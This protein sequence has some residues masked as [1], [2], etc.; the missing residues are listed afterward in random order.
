MLRNRE[1]LA[2]LTAR[3]DEVGAAQE[4]YRDRFR[5]F[6]RVLE[7]VMDRREAQ[8]P[9]PR[10]MSADEART[11][12]EGGF[13]LMDR[14][15]LSPDPA[16]SGGTFD[17]LLGLVEE[18]GRMSPEAV[19]AVRAVRGSE[20]FPDLLM[21]WFRSEEPVPAPGID[22]EDARELWG[23]LVRG[24]LKPFYERHSL[25]WSDL[26]KPGTWGEGYCP[27]CGGAPAVE[28][29]EGEEGRRV[30]LCHRCSTSWG[31][32]RVTCPFCGTR[33]HEKLRYLLIEDDPAHRVDV[34]DACKGYL[35]AA[36][37]RGLAGGVLLEAE[38]LVTPHLDVVAVRE[39]YVRK[40]PNI[41]GL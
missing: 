34:C 35:K 4:G 19:G 27:V 5:F 40:S 17:L 12:L 29:F 36:D 23:F 14:M 31:F 38:D 9:S 30:L 7:T 37:S 26:V 3:L 10:A 41:L 25:A 24:A 15:R 1:E 32:H 21:R 28:A 20:G 11:R 2:R 22:A 33:D 18:E 39:G 8:G 6:S 16:A 13:P